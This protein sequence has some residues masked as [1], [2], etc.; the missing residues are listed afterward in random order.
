MLARLASTHKQAREKCS[1]TEP[2]M[3]S[4]PFEFFVAQSV[5]GSS[6]T[7]DTP[8]Q[9][10]ERRNAERL[11]Y[12]IHSHKTSRNE[13]NHLPDKNAGQ[14]STLSSSECYPFAGRVGPAAWQATRWSVDGED[15]DL[16]LQCMC[17][18]LG[19]PFCAC[20]YIVREVAF[21]VPC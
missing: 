14:P 5:L 7:T 10:G 1:V 11:R 8:S 13:D 15:R 21:L 2:P 12:S 19:L 3:Q 16:A 9:G 4:G 20:W 17:Y 18:W 6:T